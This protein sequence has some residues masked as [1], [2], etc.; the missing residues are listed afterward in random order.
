M[1]DK[2]GVYVCEC[3]PN[4]GDKIDID[5]VLKEISALDEVSVVDRYKTLCSA[6][7]KEFLKNKIKEEG[8]THLVVAA[9]SPKQHEITFMNVCEQ[10]GINPYLF[11]LA[12][13]REQCAWIIEDK[14]EA[15]D[16]AIRHIKAA[17]GRVRYHSPLNK[18]EIESNPNVLVIG[19]GIAGI[20]SSLL[21]AGSE[22]KVFLVEKTS[23]LGGAINN[24][25]KVLP[26]MEST[27]EF[28]DQKL[29]SLE[30]NKNIEVIT[31]AEIE[32]IIG[33]FGNFEVKLKGKVLCENGK[34]DK[35]DEKD[36]EKNVEEKEFNVGAVVLATGFSLYDPGKVTKYGY[37]KFDNVL[38]AMDF[39]KM[40]TSGNIALKNGQTPKSVAIIHCVGREEKGYCSEIC[41]LYSMKFSRYLKDKLPD[42]SVTHFYSDLC[43]PGKPY[44]K[45]YEETKEKGAEFIRA[46]DVQVVEESNGIGV[47]YK[48]GA[49]AEDT[50][51]FQAD[52]IILAPAMEPS[53]D[54][55]KFVDMLMISQGETGFFTEEHEKI[56]PVSTSIEGVYITGCAQGPRSIPHTIVQS[57]AATGKILASLIPGKKIEPEVKVSVIAEEYCTGCKTCLSVCSYSAITFDEKKHVSVVNE[58]ICRGC[59]NCTASCP[60]GAITLKHFTTKQIYQELL[61][62]VG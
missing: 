34:E 57:E 33:F 45:F 31:D 29:K 38:T 49:T 51:T 62:A 21:L 36:K 13:I 10:G 47:K 30:N 11:Q 23:S 37:G 56:G 3:G 39:E 18:V 53:E 26:R 58:A 42:V 41:C 35:V 7:G 44:Q 4:I 5:R 27:H 32:H 48:T 50:N 40:N 16:K 59:G 28:L 19:G 54:A 17:I 1:V 60:S 9:C 61:E 20:T 46:T 6:D 43:V 24:F 15:T 2:I 8:L 25:E 12:N 55:S 22:R 52:M 14:E